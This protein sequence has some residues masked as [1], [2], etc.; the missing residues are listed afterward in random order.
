MAGSN[1]GSVIQGTI[2]ASPARNGSSEARAPLATFS[3]LFTTARLLSPTGDDGAG[4]LSIEEVF[5]RLADLPSYTTWMHRTGMFRR[6]D[7][8]SD[9][10]LG[11]GTTYFDATRMGTYRGEVTTFERPSRIAGLSQIFKCAKSLMKQLLA[12][13]HSLLN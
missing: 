5:A 11:K 7:Q 9:G 10:P 8:T 3:V 4:T 13:K 2:R 6:C 1:S 12:A